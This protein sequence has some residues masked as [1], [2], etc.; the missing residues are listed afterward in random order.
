MRFVTLT[1]KACPE[2]GRR[3]TF[4]MATASWSATAFINVTLR[5]RDGQIDDITVFGLQML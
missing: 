4:I 3:V 1:R 2:Q 5:I